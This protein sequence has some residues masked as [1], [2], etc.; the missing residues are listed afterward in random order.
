MAVLIVA[1]SVLGTAAGTLGSQITEWIGLGESPIVSVLLRAAGFLVAAGVSMLTW[2][3]LF[4]LTAAVRP[5]RKDLLLGAAVGGIVVQ[6]VL[7]L[8]TSLVSSASAAPTDAPF[9][10]PAAR[11]ARRRTRWV[12]GS[13]SV[14][15]GS[16][17]SV[18]SSSARA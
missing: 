4:R 2:I 6:I 10:G 17:K 9:G 16:T 15:T 14:T 11:D 7:T 5:P 1:S 13:S 3:Q 12:V 18:M 8:G